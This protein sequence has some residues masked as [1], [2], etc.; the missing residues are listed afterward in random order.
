[1]TPSELEHWQYSP[2][3]VRLALALAIGLF[4]GIERERR[5][6]GAG[7]RTFACAALLGATGGLLGPPFALL[8]LGLLGI[9]VVLLNVE[10]L[11]AGQGAE[12]TTSAAL[13]LTGFAGVLAGQGHTFTPTV[14]GV[15]TAALLAWK[16]PLAGFSHALTESELRSAILLA[17]LAFVVY[18]I[19]PSGSVDPWGLIAPRSA[20]VTVILIAALGFANYILLKLYGTRGVELTGFLGGL[21]NSTVT[22]AELANRARQAGDGLSGVVFR[23]VVLATAAM[24]VRNAVILGLL[25][26][27]ALL[28]SVIPFTLMLIGCAAALLVRGQAPKGATPRQS[29]RTSAGDSVTVAPIPA[30]QSPFSLTEVVKFGVLLLVL[31][32]A[33][34]GA[35]RWLGQAGFYAVS[36]VGGFVS[37]ASAVASAANL[38]AAGTL[39]PQVAGTGAVLAS[40][41][42]AIVNWPLVARLTKDRG[43][44]RRLAWVLSVVVLLGVAGAAVQAY[45]HWSP[46][47]MM[48]TRAQD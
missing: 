21:V 36:V 28:S 42:S 15:A 16:Q 32:L 48:R 47:S 39:P 44:A 10:T 6:K 43:L 3:L 9:L 23:G 5:E 8:A 18:P 38:V 12:M 22:V 14:L 35:E 31:Q 4:V 2:T 26:P 17:I 30:L 27:V 41:M 33:A 11:R 13:L 40:L 29:A 20:W 7:V 34:T 25:A 1:M 45:V 37:S 19:L 46:L 24:L